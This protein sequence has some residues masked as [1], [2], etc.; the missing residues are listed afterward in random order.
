MQSIKRVSAY[1]IN[2]K[3]KRN[4]SFWQSESYDHLIRDEQELLDIINY[5]LLNPDKAG[6]VENWKDYK[7]NYFTESW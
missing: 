1:K 2:L 3:L 4:G 5:T 7:Y 6:I